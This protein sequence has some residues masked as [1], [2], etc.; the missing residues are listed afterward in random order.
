MTVGEKGED[1]ERDLRVV[2]RRRSEVSERPDGGL[3]F[4]LQ[5]LLGYRLLRVP[6]RLLGDARGEIDGCRERRAAKKSVQQRDHCRHPRGF[7]AFPRALAHRERA[8]LSL[9]ATIHKLTALAAEHVGIVGRGVIRPGAAA[10]LVLF[11][12]ER[13]AD[14]A[15]VAEPK[16]TAAGIEQVWVNGVLV[17]SEGRATGARPG[18]VI[19]RATAP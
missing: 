12:P 9:E 15:T 10:D 2:A 11:D 6:R 18:V 16:R 1:T 3:F 7:G 8:G 14:R 4:S 5:P 17:W 19:R 13:I